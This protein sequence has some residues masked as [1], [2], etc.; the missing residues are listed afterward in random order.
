MVKSVDQYILN[1]LARKVELEALR[2]ILLK[3]DLVEEV[4]WGAPVYTVAGKNIVGIGA[5]KS[6][7]GLW[8][9]QGALL[10]DKDKVLINA[11][12]GKTKA[13]RQ[14]RFTSI[15]D[16]NSELIKL[17][18]LEAIKNSKEGR[19]IKPVKPQEAIIPPELVNLLESDNTLKSRFTSFTPY[20]Q[21]E[22]AEY[23]IEAKRTATKEARL[24]RIKPMILK[25][26]GLHD[27]YR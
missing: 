17:Y 18:L 12:E 5:F 6:Y 25:G 22:F 7:V 2:G 20:K 27:K 21:K 4:K 1:H 9:Y 11:Q 19:V 10:A 24:E 23:I 13:L 16:I 15:S 3:V 26:V 14:W 8:F